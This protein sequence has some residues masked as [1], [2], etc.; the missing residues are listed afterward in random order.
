[1]TIAV[2][3]AGGQLGRAVVSR[4]RAAGL[5][6][7]A[8][9]RADV[10]I[11]QPSALA[12]VLGACRPEAVINAAAFARVDEAEDDP[13]GVFARS[14][15]E[16]LA[17]QLAERGRLDPAMQ[18][19][20]DRLDL[21]AKRDLGQLMRVCGVDAEDL[22]EMIAEIKALNPKPGSAFDQSLVQPVVPDIV[23]RPQPGGDWLIEL[24]S[25]TLPR[26]LVNNVLVS[27]RV[28][29]KVVQVDNVLDLLR[30]PDKVVKVVLADK[31]VAHKVAHHLHI[32]QVVR[33]LLVV[34]HHLEKV[35][36]VVPVQVVAVIL[37][38]HLVKVDQRRVI[39][40]RAR[41]RCVMILRTCKR[42]YLV[43]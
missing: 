2:L 26:V 22:K 8:L 27:P 18:A 40:K 4:A 15:G 17:Y 7:V 38:A 23:M 34:A 25:E 20:L 39:S 32:N 6:T 3:G 14:L 12:R 19:M 31:V 43:A 28:P 36:V 35:K 11:T 5:D 30:V 16:C 41:R 9:T 37:L 1:M 24:N 10:D 21:L 33:V 42:Q 29:V 13:A